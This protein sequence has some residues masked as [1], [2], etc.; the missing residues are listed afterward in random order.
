VLDRH[1]GIADRHH[2]LL[3]AGEDGVAAVAAADG[4]LDLADGLGREA[5]SEKLPEEAVAVWDPSCG[6]WDHFEHA[7]SIPRIQE[8]R[9]RP[10]SGRRTVSG[11]ERV[12]ARL[13]ELYALGSTRIGYSPEEDAA[14]RLAARWLA[15]AGL[16]VETDAAGNT[17]G[18]RGGAGLWLGSHVDTVPDGGRF[19]GALGVVAAVEVA[20]RTSVPL[21]VAVF[22]DEERGCAGSRA[23]VQAGRL[24]GCFLELHVEQ[25]PVL[26]RAGAPLGVVTG[27][28]GQ[29][30]GERVFAG[31]ADHAGTTPMAAR[32]DAL[33]KA[34]AFV[35][36]AQ[37]GA[38][39][40]TVPTVGRV[41][42]EPGAAN[43]VPA[44]VTVSIDARAPTTAQL[45]VL[46]ERLGFEPSYRTEPVAMS[47]PALAALR[48][49]APGAP[50]L[51]SGAGH[52]A[53]ILAAA[54]VPAGMLFVRSLNGG[55]SH[56]PEELSSAEDVARAVAALERAAVRI[57]G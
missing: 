1:E 30:R 7:H 16:E 55:A 29:V 4:D 25:G 51:V 5:G 24:P 35:L 39:P 14:H 46:V 17:F 13:E 47:D 52:D 44:R 40:D 37:A 32:D 41:E 6:H 23:C 22:R 45:D 3:G 43:V 10:L 26:E 50:E 36:E 48:A 8:L 53:G 49:A 15:E 18:R 12:L 21:G 20:E 34:A 27:I 57:A 31:H 19:D 33:V 56:S 2:E 54:G 9:Q 11:V 42:V 38:G 28:V